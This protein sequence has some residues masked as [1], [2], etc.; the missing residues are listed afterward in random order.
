LSSSDLIRWGG[1]VAIWGGVLWALWNAGL[2]FVVGWG[3]PPSP[4][5]ERYEAYNRVMPVILPLLVAGLLGFHAAQ[6][7]GYG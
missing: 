7:G 5:Y 4:S 1:L 3:E 2:E 6:K